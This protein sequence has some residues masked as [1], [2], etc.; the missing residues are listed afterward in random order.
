MT[1][2]DD[3]SEF[4]GAP[5]MIQPPPHVPTAEEKRSLAMG[6]MNDVPDDTEEEVRKR[7][8]DRLQ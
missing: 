4:G 8:G 7:R 3:E 1:R 2:P 6:V 5:G